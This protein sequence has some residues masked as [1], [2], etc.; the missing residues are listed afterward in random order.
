MTDSITDLHDIL[1]ITD[2][3]L[4]LRRIETQ[5]TQQETTMAT[6]LE[7]LAALAAQQSATSEAQTTAFRN[8][9]AAIDRLEDAVRDGEVSPEVQAAVAE[10]TAGFDAMKEA[11]DRADDGY[12]P[13]PDVPAEP[14]PE[15]PQDETPTVP[16]E[17]V[18][19]DENQAGRRR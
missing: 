9:Q 5:L 6:V 10:L 19:V 2:L 8:L 16:V 7:A 15:Q 11:A 18:P 3:R 12:E 17:D 4:R 1:G 13:T 14:T